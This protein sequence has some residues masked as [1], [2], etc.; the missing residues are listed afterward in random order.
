MGLCA[1]AVI[2]LLFT[3]PSHAA[4]LFGT[5]GFFPVDG[6]PVNITAIDLDSQDPIDIA[7][8]NEAGA[9]G[10]SL[11]FLVNRGAG[12]FLPERRRELD[13]LTDPRSLTSGDFNIAADSNDDI[14]VAAF[15]VNNFPPSAAALILRGRG[16]V[17]FSAAQSFPAGGLEPSCIETADIDGDRSLDLVL[18]ISAE[19]GGSAQ[20]R[21]SLLRG[22]GAG[23][24]M[25][26]IEHNVGVGPSTLAIGLL[27]GDNL[28]DLVVGDRD[29][30]RVFVMYGR[31]SEPFFDAPVILTE[32]ST[33]SAVAIADVNSPSLPDILVTNRNSG[34]L[35]VFR[36]TAA[37]TFA[38]PSLVQIGQQPTDMGVADF[39]DDG[40]ADVVVTSATQGSVRL[41][42][43]NGSGGFTFGES[44]TI[45]PSPIGSSSTTSTTTGDWTSPLGSLARDMVSVVLNGADV[46]ATPTPSPTITP[47]PSRTPIRP[48]TPRAPA[49]R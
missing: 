1:A 21:V 29:A 22:R 14:A 28:P 45:A 49:R 32:L 6:G 37:R 27:D 39:N 11:S 20:G 36:Q 13:P 44:V 30:R 38:A 31:P 4:P 26:P 46:P 8:V 47:T 24:F 23:G 35:F 19:T 18:A 16:D 15:D 2:L 17:G 5:P 12:S 40:R 42:H 25:A 33:P 9:E 48:P 3:P 34:Q 10:P 7:S 43:G 41:W